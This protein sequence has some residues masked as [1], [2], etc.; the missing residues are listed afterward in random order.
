[1][2]LVSE[3]E[4]QEHGV[5]RGVLLGCILVFSDELSVAVCGRG[6]KPP[7]LPWWRSVGTIRNSD[8]ELVSAG[9][10]AMVPSS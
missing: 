10:V 5:D 4:N 2:R 8:R 7:I 3:M 9:A 1:M 6:R